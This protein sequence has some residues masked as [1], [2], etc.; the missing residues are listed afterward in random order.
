MRATSVDPSSLER[1]MAALTTELPLSFAH[2]PLKRVEKRDARSWYA[3]EKLVGKG[4]FGRV[5]SAQ[6][7]LM[8]GSQVAIKSYFREPGAAVCCR[9][10]ISNP[11]SSRSTASSSKHPNKRPPDE[12]ALD[13]KRVRQEVKMMAAL[14]PHPNIIQFIEAF[15]TPT[16]M[17]VVMEFV[18]GENLCDHL[19]RTDA[20][21]LR[22]SDPEA[23]EIFRQVCAAVASLHDQHV[24]HRDLKLENVLVDK[25]GRAKLIDFGFSQFD[26]SGT[27]NGNSGSGSDAASAKNFCGTPSYMAPEVVTSASYD[28][29]SVDVW[30]LGVLLYVLL[31]GKFPFQGQSFHQLYQSIL[32][33]SSSPKG[34]SFPGG[35]SKDAQSLIR[36]VLVVDPRKRPRVH[37]I[38]AH[39][40]TMTTTA[41]SPDGEANKSVQRSPL[42]V[43]NL[44]H[45]ERFFFA[46]LQWDEA[47]ARFRE[48]LVQFY[49]LNGVEL[50][51]A[52]REKRKNG[53]TA[54]IRLAIL[55]AQKKTLLLADSA[56]STH[57]ESSGDSNT[58]ISI[59]NNNGSRSGSD[60]GESGEST[61]EPAADGPTHKQHLEK[62]IGL[63]KASLVV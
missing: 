29:K 12:D 9:P 11:S 32:R 59:S 15:E 28:G 16:Q 1:L 41:A 4:T 27:S 17:H 60:S 35:L 25:R 38:L 37:D 33:L 58:C 18:K 13:W 14:R 21:T 30:S 22:L 39:P 52:L 34:W 42:V 5:Y 62:L 49:G 47:Q 3:F 40:W 54:F 51:S 31:C 36:S 20:S 8:S 19:R 53:V 43:G 61:E 7:R 63:V 57:S 45:H 50:K 48:A 56:T 44:R 2:N 23:R 24:I 26:Y 46:F 6:H 10:P 55:T